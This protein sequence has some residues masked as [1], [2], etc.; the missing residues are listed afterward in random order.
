MERNRE[1]LRKWMGLNTE[2]G[3]PTY[4]LNKVTMSGDDGKFK[5]TDLLSE[6]PKGEKP[7]NEDLGE[8][9][10]GVIL[11][12]RWQLTRFDETTSLSSTEY[13]NKWK[14]E[15]TVYPMKEKGNAATMKEKHSLNTVRVVYF[16]VPKKAQIV[17]LIVKASALTGGEKN[18]GGEHGLFEYI[19]EYAQTETLPCE[20]ITACKG[21]F[22]EGKNADGSKN[23]RKDHY[24][25]SFKSGRELTDSEFEKVEA[26]M[27]E[28]NEKTS[29]VKP[30]TKPEI[31]EDVAGKGLEASSQEI[32]LNDIPF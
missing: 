12:M 13:D 32:D 5:L 29:A 8:V 1:E 2:G 22:R 30:E 15:V 18:P 24:A 19:D 27:I 3:T 25:M 6:R 23:K 7:N 11:K 21:V 10:E 31:E 14:D 9:I 28:V 16:Y 4:K 17:R 26:M 20:F